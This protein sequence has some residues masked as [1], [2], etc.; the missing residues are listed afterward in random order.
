MRLTDI[1]VTWRLAF[2]LAIPLLAL[3]GLAYVEINTTYVAYIN[4]REL[5]V[6]SRDLGIIGDLVHV[7]QSERAEAVG[8]LATKGVRH[9]TELTSA[10]AA[11]DSNLQLVA[12]IRADIRAEGDPTLTRHEQT[13]EQA[14]ADLTTV[15][16][17]IDAL[18]I[19]QTEAFTY[20]TDLVR[21]L[22]NISQ[23][24]SLD[25]GAR[26][27]VG[28]MMAYS[29]LMNAKEVAGQERNLGH[30][31]IAEGKFNEAHYLDFI[32]MFGSQM[33]LISQYLDLVPEDDRERY[34][35]SLHTPDAEAVEKIRAA[36]M[37]A[38][39]AADLTGF[40]DQEWLERSAKRIERLKELENETLAAIIADSQSI[41]DGEY[42]HLLKVGGITGSVLTLAF[43]LAV[44]LSL[45][46][47]RPLRRLT[48]TMHRL[49]AGEIEVDL[50]QS[51]SKDEIGQM[52]SA[53]SRYIAL[54]KERML[55]EIAEQEE[56]E[57][58]KRQAEKAAEQ[59]RAARAAEIAFAVEQLG[60]GLDALS[61]GE[62]GFRLQSPFADTLDALRTNFN[63]SMD[64][65]CGIMATIRES[66][67]HLHGGS[68]E[69]QIATDD[70]AR[71]TER[72]AAALEEAAASINEI[73]SALGSAA[74]RAD[75]AGSL[76]KEATHT[77]Q[78]S[79]SVV[80]ETV[81]A[82]NHIEQS[83]GQIGQIIGVI[84]EIAFQTNLLA[85]NAGVE[86]AR[87]GES[88]RG[89]AV[90]AQEV[91]ELAQRSATAAREIK[92]LISRSTQ[93]VAAGVRLVHE[94]GETLRGI[95]D[96]VQKINERV[97]AIVS[98][99]HEQKAALEEI[100][101][102]VSQMDQVTQQNAAMV[103]EASAATSSVATEADRLNAQIAMFR[104][105]HE[106]EAPSSGRHAA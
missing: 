42:H 51:D 100:S 9:R 87:A 18:G 94:T 6:V 23:E 17:K 52:G 85:L 34:A 41:A 106:N 66:T 61:T 8:L 43:F 37:K 69:L 72:Q 11:V 97:T 59:E 56:A 57:R 27:V 55:K 76:V 101:Q 54:A 91:R 46:V 86:A 73:T 39:L 63:G 7:L 22:M 78:H 5:G 45:T 65:L 31:F 92:A 90:V 67:G 68:H 75:E 15:R 70:L 53:V 21:N 32:G 2:A 103:E 38:G 16:S 62:I 81:T 104:L 48:A 12:R 71:R 74:K 80:G 44:S 14:L 25:A 60:Q 3:A 95:E 29:L 83:S 105:P 58:I 88:G 64:R 19:S 96:F 28:K 79:G 99:A 20:Y 26:G 1:S 30:S 47:V 36:M 40:D 50:I 98:S 89:F 10:R 102:A 49:A 24:F 93:E 4:A 84:D 13:L 77:A 33:S 35:A 82:M